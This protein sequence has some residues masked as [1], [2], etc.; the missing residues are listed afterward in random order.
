LVHAATPGSLGLNGWAIARLDHIPLIG[1]YHTYLPEYLSRRVNKIARKFKLPAESAARESER[2]MWDYVEWFYNQTKP[3]LA[4]S[5]HTKSVLQERFNTKIGIFSRGVDTDTFHPRYRK[6]PDQVTVLYVG[7]V[8]TEKN[9]DVLP[10]V[11]FALGLLEAVR[12]CL[13]LP[14]V[15]VHG[16]YHLFAD[17]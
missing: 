14:P 8:S 13:D 9:L 10:N 11:P 1:S 2:L 16:R 3:V 15:V 4:L 5:Q 12:T 6:E 17:R 7:R